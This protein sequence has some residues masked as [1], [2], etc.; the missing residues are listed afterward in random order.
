MTTT[1]MTVGE[2]IAILNKYPLDAV[3]RVTVVD[4]E[5]DPRPGHMLNDDQW[6]DT[7][8]RR[9]TVDT[10]MKYRRQVDGED[11]DVLHVTIKHADY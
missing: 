3:V 6:A 1:P 7:V 4:D 10:C 11:M 2:L 5:V 8:L 9:R